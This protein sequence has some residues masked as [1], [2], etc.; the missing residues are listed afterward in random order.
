M[1]LEPIQWER[2]NQEPRL[3]INDF[4]IPIYRYHGY[5]KNRMMARGSDERHVEL[6][7]RR[8][9]QKQA[10]NNRLILDRPLQ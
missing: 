5:L 2:Y 7:N 8:N 10:D 3:E 1:S 9:H 6:E 4:V